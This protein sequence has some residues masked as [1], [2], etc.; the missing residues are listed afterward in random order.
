MKQLEEA[1]GVHEWWMSNYNLYVTTCTM[2]DYKI[3]RDG[4]I[5]EADW[6]RDR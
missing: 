5:S 4:A 2:N 1:V 6:S 3:T